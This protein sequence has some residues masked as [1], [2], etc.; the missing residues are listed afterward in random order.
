MKLT[1][2]KLKQIIKEELTG[3]LREQ[4]SRAQKL[5]KQIFGD[6]GALKT[7]RA[8]VFAKAKELVKSAP[9]G[10]AAPGL[11]FEEA[12]ENW[13]GQMEDVMETAVNLYRTMPEEGKR[14]FIENFKMYAQRWQDELEGVEED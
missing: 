14:H 7:S 6:L 8:D 2:S 1:K 9:A 3:V 10:A 4:E 5:R 12:A 13:V 11:K